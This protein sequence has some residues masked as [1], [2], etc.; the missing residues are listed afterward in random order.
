MARTYKAPNELISPL[1]TIAMLN[2][3][4]GCD[5]YGRYPI[6]VAAKDVYIKISW[7][8]TFLTDNTSL[9]RKETQ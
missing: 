5:Q 1:C 9:V 8:L 6:I 3:E 7:F 4:N 2:E